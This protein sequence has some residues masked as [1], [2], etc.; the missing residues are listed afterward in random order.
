MVQLFRRGPNL[1]N[2]QW[3]EI[4]KLI[5]TKCSSQAVI[6]ELCKFIKAKLALNTKYK[7]LF[8]GNF[9]IEDL[10]RFK[11]VT[12]EVLESL[13]SYLSWVI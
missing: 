7:V 9:F 12:V 2:F 11:L 13:Q 1:I 8:R 3:E 6:I 4:V 5:E 10:S